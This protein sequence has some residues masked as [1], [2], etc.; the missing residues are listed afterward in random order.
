MF[1]EVQFENF[2]E[3]VEQGRIDGLEIDETGL[4]ANHVAVHSTS[5]MNIKRNVVE[6]SEANDATDKLEEEQVI[7]IDIR[8]SIRLERR[9]FTGR[10][11]ESIIGIDDLLTNDLEPFTGQ[12]TCVSTFLLTEANLHRASKLL[13]SASSDQVETLR[14]AVLSGDGEIHLLSVA[15]EFGNLLAELFLFELKVDESGGVLEELEGPFEERWSPVEASVHK[16]AVLLQETSDHVWKFWF[17]RSSLLQLGDGLFG[18]FR[19]FIRFTHQDF[20]FSTLHLRRSRITNFTGGGNITG[21]SL[22]KKDIVAVCRRET[23][24]TC[25]VTTSTSRRV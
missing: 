3:G 25:V 2:L 16:E 7:R 6:K 9:T 10:V 13:R 17:G 4:D 14:E 11:E 23:T 5:E 19:D 18:D 21:I 15:T 20:S 24:A 12:T 22:L 8:E 1:G